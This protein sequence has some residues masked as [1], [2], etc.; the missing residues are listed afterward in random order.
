MAIYDLYSKRQ[1]RL[2]GEVPDVYQYDNIS[3]ILRVQIVHIWQDALGNEKEY[4]ACLDV[5]ALY[6]FIVNILC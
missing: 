1:K 2:C 5:K 3:N 4:F 6:K